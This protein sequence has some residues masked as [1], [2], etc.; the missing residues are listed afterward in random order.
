MAAVGR[1][2]DAEKRL[3]RRIVRPRQLAKRVIVRVA[4]HRLAVRKEAVERERKVARSERNRRRDGRRRVNG[5]EVSPGSNGFSAEVVRR[6]GVPAFDGERSGGRVDR[7]RVG[8]VGVRRPFVNISADFALL[9]FADRKRNRR[10]ARRRRKSRSF[11]N[12]FFRRRGLQRIIGIEVS[13]RSKRLRAE[14]V[15][16]VRLQTD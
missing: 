12:V 8:K 14:V 16:R 10:S 11:Q 3:G 1:I 7:S 5:V 2:L 15:R 6:V 4:R 9:N 13:S